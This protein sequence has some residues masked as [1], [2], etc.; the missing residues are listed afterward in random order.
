M[1]LRNFTGKQHREEPSTNSSGWMKWMD[2][3]RREEQNSIPVFFR[4]DV[5]VDAI[6]KQGND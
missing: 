6:F 3:S 1:E 4:Q 5:D 2:T